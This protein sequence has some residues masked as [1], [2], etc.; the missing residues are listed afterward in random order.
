TGAAIEDLLFE[1]N[2]EAGTTL[3]VVTHDDELAART[4]RVIR[5]RDGRIVEDSGHLSQDEVAK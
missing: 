4:G 2:A 5:L 3:V 1:I